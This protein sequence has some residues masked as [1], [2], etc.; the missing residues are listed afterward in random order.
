[1]NWELLLDEDALARLLP[2]EYAQFARP[3]KE[4]L[5]VFLSGLPQ[6]IQESI[7]AEQATLPTAASIALRLGRLAR[8]CPVLHKLGQILARDPRLAPELRHQFRQLE[9]LPPMVHQNVIEETLSRELGPLDRRGIT[10]LPPAIAEASVAVVIPFRQDAGPQPLEGVFKILKPGIEARLNLELELLGRVGSHLDQEC[11]K[12]RIPPLDYR[13]TFEK[14]RHKLA[15]E[16]LLDQEQCHLAEAKVFYAEQSDVQIPTVLLDHCT[17]RITAMERIAGEK[18]TEHLLRC[19]RGKRRLSDLVSRA[20]VAQPMFCRSNHALFH[21]DP[22]AGNLFYTNDGRLAILDWSLVG[23]LGEVERVAI[24]QIFLG[25]ITMRTEKIVTVLEGLSERENADRSA[26]TQVVAGWLQRVR[27]GQFPGV[28]WLLGMLDEAAQFAGLR[29]SS[30]MLLFRK[31][32]LILEGVVGEIGAEGHWVD[33]IAVGEFMRHF[34]GELPTR[35]FSPPASRK[36]AT[37]LSNADLAEA[38]FCLPLTVARYWL[39]EYGDLL[40]NL[41]SP[42]NAPAR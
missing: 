5:V 22:H 3:V 4:G 30:D 36:F 2:G 29:V 26:L 8:S 41:L 33:D 31:S 24:G 32:L 34:A 6:A 10:L 20:L 9:S 13:G 14:V 15:G 40:Q 39:A 12:L 18:V 25:A 27:L 37:R 28:S 17:S 42:R 19:P 11:D 16:V 7:L 35:C 38:F 21:S 23:Y 1:M